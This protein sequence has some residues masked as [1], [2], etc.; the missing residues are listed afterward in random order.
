MN[1]DDLKQRAEDVEAT[2]VEQQEEPQLTPEQK[3]MQDKFLRGAIVHRYK[4]ALKNLYEVLKK[5]HCTISDVKQ[6]ILEKTKTLPF[7]ASQRN[8][9]I[10]FKDE[11]LIEC[12]KDLYNEKQLNEINLTISEPVQTGTGNTGDLQSNS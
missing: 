9:I 12:L 5:R 6:L 4:Q 11:F 2:P 7:T 10:Y 1:I 3:E 8:F